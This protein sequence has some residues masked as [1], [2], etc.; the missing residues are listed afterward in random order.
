METTPDD[1][2]NGEIDI[3]DLYNICNGVLRD[4]LL[5]LSKLDE[6]SD[7][8]RE[9][10]NVARLREIWAHTATGCSKCESIVTKLNT[11]RGALDRE[12]S[13]I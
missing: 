2:H 5:D 3:Y 9:S 12:V 1:F 13:L 6:Y 7:E 10:L 8:D 4:G 11:V